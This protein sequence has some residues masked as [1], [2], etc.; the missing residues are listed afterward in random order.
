LGC[1][2]FGNDS[3]PIV[4]IDVHYFKRA[5]PNIVYRPLSDIHNDDFFLKITQYNKFDTKVPI[6]AIPE[7]S[8]NAKNIIPCKPK[9]WEDIQDSHIL[10]VGGQHTIVATKVHQ[11]H[12]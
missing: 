2:P 8:H 10:I 9:K 12:P 6:F 7:D 11:L 4:S 3:L 1:F 5:P